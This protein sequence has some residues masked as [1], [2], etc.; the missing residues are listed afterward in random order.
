MLS[1]VHVQ[2]RVFS[3]RCWCA[4]SCWRLLFRRQH[5]AVWEDRCTCILNQFVVVHELRPQHPSKDR[6]PPERCTCTRSVLKS[7]RK[8]YVAA[9]HLRH[10]STTKP[11]EKQ[12]ALVRRRPLDATSAALRYL[13]ATAGTNTQKGGME[14]STSSRKS[15]CIGTPP[16]SQRSGRPGGVVSYATCGGK[17]PTTSAKRR[18][19]ATPESASY[20][21]VTKRTARTGLQVV[22]V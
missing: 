4:V 18:K 3:L 10:S 1:S 22:Y 8:R 5:S 20:S 21:A 9:K 13:T 6:K 12:L 7:R 16:T 19:Q 17:H 2:A 11:T 15:G 14:K